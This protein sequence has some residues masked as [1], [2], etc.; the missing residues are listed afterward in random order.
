[1]IKNKIEKLHC[2]Y[3][4]ISSGKETALH[5]IAMA[6]IPEMVYNSNAIENST[7]TLEETEK[8]LLENIAPK[9]ANMREVFEAKNLAKITEYLLCN[10]G[11][12][13]NTKLVLN[14]HKMLLSNIEDEIAGRF[15]TGNEWVR[16]GLHLGANPLFVANLMNDLIKKYNTTDDIFY[17]DK[18]AFFHADF[19]TI[20]PFCD[21][22]GRIGRVL[23]NQQLIKLGYPPIIIQ[24]KSKLKEYY[25]LFNIYQT[26]QKYDGF[27][28]LF[29]LLLLES[30]HKRLSILTCP[31]IIPLS[32]WAEKNTVKG[33][34]AANKAKRQTIPA[35]R[36]RDKWVISDKYR[37]NIDIFT[38]FHENLKSNYIEISNSQRP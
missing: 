25:P 24:N 37:E 36:L 23:I 16:V 1:M 38:Y 29:T 12:E 8:I 10:K 4:E 35:F 7:L 21:G 6:E 3:K 33:N 13:L 26:T 32:V 11:L 22:N 18:I 14:L 28:S 34:I 30:L 19:E 17:M 20:H 5:E 2:L 27:S 15:R 31:K 9:Q